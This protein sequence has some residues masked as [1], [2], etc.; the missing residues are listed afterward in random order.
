MTDTTDKGAAGTGDATTS[1][2]D[3]KAQV[4]AFEH[5]NFTL[6]AQLAELNKKFSGIDP[7]EVSRLRNKVKEA[8]KASVAADPKKLEE[9]E[10]TLKAEYD[11]TYGTE[12]DNLRGLT[13][14]Q[15]QEIKE[16][17]LTTTVIDRA[18]QV[19]KKDM[20][21]LIKREVLA[22]CDIR[23]GKVVILG[24]DKKGD[25]RKS[26]RNPRSDM[27]IDE[28]IEELSERYPSA[29]E[30]KNKAGGM[31]G[32]DKRASVPTTLPSDFQSWNRA[33]QV[34]FMQKNPEIRAKVLNGGI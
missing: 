32:A 12:L 10:A 30:S 16:L 34:E 9:Y 24:E 25:P 20:L 5:D 31:N 8:T 19:F 26:P 27:T 22:A 15:T 14:K 11:K 21:P 3:L 29:V 4:A 23:E 28:F 6:K 2:D 1:A 33:E 18:A 13:A 7:E 17:R